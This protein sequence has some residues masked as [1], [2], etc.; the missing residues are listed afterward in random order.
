MT[1]T[2]AG[3]ER[4]IG[5]TWERSPSLYARVK[6][7][8]YKK[9]INPETAHQAYAA[10]FVIPTRKRKYINRGAK[11]SNAT[12][13]YNQRKTCLSPDALVNKLRSAWNNAESRTSKIAK[14]LIYDLSK[15]I[16]KMI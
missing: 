8:Q 15:A 1:N 6:K 7:I 10:G 13:E 5:Y 14:V 11:K 4:I 12:R 2:S 3:D 16:E 9:W